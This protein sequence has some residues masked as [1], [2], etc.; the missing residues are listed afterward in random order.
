MGNSDISDPSRIYFSLGSNLGDR[1]ANLKIG[2]S[3][4][5]DYFNFVSASH[6][7]ES[8][9]WG[10]EDPNPYLNMVACFSTTCSPLDI[11]Q[12]IASIETKAGRKSRRPSQLGYEART[13]DIDVLFYG[14]LISKNPEILIPHPRLHLRNFVLEPLVQLAPDLTHP[15]LKKNM[16]QLLDESP[17]KSLV[18]YYA[19][20]V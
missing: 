9:S 15:I 10:Y 16:L 6:I 8:V 7:I 11:R 13:L 14:S 5:S 20:G 1:L 12:H 2:I 3:A 4:L 19:D 17:D 18:K